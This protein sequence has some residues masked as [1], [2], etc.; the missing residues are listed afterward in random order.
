[1]K[2]KSNL[3]DQVLKL[4]RKRR[5]ALFEKIALSLID[6][7]VLIAGA[8]LAEERWQAY[9][10]GEVGAKPA[11]EAIVALMKKKQKK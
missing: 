7:D 10:R 4:P 9:R 11:R 1:M 5:A 6:E 8:Q 2:S 3:D